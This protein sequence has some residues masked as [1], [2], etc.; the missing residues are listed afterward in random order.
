[1][2]A[3]R[4][5]LALTVC[6]A[7]IGAVAG[8]VV[9]VFSSDAQ[10]LPA[11]VAPDPAV[12]GAGG[13]GCSPAPAA[14]PGRDA[15]AQT[16]PAVVA[17]PGLTQRLDAG[18]AAVR[19][20][21]ALELLRRGPSALAQARALRPASE[22]GRALQARLIAAL[23]KMRLLRRAGDYGRLPQHIRL[24]L[25]LDAF[26]T[27]VPERLLLDERR[28]Y[29]EREVDAVRA[30]LAQGYAEPAEESVAL[31]ELALARRESGELDAASY[32]TQARRLLPAVDSWLD[33]RRASGRMAPAELTALEQQI[34][35]LRP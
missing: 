2:V 27:V 30:R 3:P 32:V 28:A 18:D 5:L 10:R 29:W 26:A 9:V 16:P 23:S 13:V 19:H 33:D 7:A 24:R 21:L 31:L 1:M 8:V 11:E 25:D 34:A 4:T 12:A 15:S 20:E 22:A 35:R 17:S 14:R 6:A